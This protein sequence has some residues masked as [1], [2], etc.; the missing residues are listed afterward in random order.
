MGILEVGIAS[1]VA[2]GRPKMTADEFYE[3][4]PLD[5]RAMLSRML[6]AFAV[7]AIV[8]DGLELSDGAGPQM[9]ADRIV[10]SGDR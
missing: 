7:F 4:Q 2:R 1:W 9:A 8:I 5:L 10:V 6:M 3:I